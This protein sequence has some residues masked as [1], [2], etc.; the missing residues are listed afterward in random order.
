MT[1][2]QGSAGGMAHQDT[3]VR[4]L[5][6]GLNANVTTS[7]V[8]LAYGL[9]HFAT[10]DKWLAQQVPVPSTAFSLQWT[11]PDLVVHQ[12]M[13]RCLIH[14]PAVNPTHSWLTSH[15]PFIIRYTPSDV[16]SPPPYAGTPAG[17]HPPDSFVGVND[18]D[19]LLVN[20]IR[21]MSVVGCCW[22]VGLKFA[23]TQS[24]IA[25][26]FVREYYQWLR[27]VRPLTTT[28]FPS[29]LAS[30]VSHPAVAREVTV[31]KHTHTLAKLM[32]VTALT[33]IVAGSGHSPTKRI[34]M[35]EMRSSSNLPVEVIYGVKL[36]MQQ[37]L[38]LLFIGGGQL[39]LRRDPLATALLLVATYPRLPTS[40]TD[41]RYHLQ[42]LRFLTAL[43]T[44]SRLLIAS[45]EV[46]GCVVKPAMA[47]IRVKV[48]QLEKTSDKN[49]SNLRTAT[50]LG[51]GRRNKK[52][53]SEHTA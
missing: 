17:R 35:G 26:R 36:S 33:L 3:S 24:K 31:D 22:A 51:A 21:V 23:G 15:L 11:R 16:T 44:Q 52:M 34:I 2:G 43:C 29:V 30:L 9:L 37:A 13:A 47:T 7:G 28:S 1:S 46:S 32:L 10:C 4:Y 14:W 12:I 48:E 6:S 19:W 50:S 42:S 8:C 49:K 45:D 5:E 41:N 25:W 18:V 53:R 40:A 27:S 39:T 38:G 20:Q